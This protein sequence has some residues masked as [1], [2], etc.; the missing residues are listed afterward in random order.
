MKILCAPTAIAR[1][2]P[3]VCH[4]LAGVE[5]TAAAI[6]GHT[7]TTTSAATITRTDPLI[8]EPSTPLPLQIILTLHPYGFP[9]RQADGRS[10]RPILRLTAARHPPGERVIE[11]LVRNCKLGVRSRRDLSE[12]LAVSPRRL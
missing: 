10:T 9:P 2:R 8:G 12:T 3:F 5:L 11:P 1:T 6:A 7:A 4:E